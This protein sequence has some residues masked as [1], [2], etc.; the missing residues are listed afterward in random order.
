M[1]FA[2]SHDLEDKNTFDEISVQDNR[3]KE[4]DELAQAIA[5]S[6]RS[7]TTSNLEQI[8]PISKASTKVIDVDDSIIDIT[9]M[10]I[11]QRGFHKDELN[12]P[13]E[14]LEDTTITGNPSVKIQFKFPEGKK[15]TKAFSCHENILIVAS[16][17]VSQ[18][19]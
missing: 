12:L 11:I 17:V 16:F 10:P 13:H 6:I 7:S 15:V 14:T 2:Y 3:D 5:L 19:S 18:V 9:P 1:D 4:D 8:E